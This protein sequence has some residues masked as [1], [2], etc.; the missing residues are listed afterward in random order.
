MDTA[1]LVPESSVEEKKAA[2]SRGLW[3]LS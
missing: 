2:F 1:N 3:E